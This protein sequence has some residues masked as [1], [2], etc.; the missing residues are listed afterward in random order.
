LMK[1]L[2][3]FSK[4][5]Y[6]T[7]KTNLTPEEKSVTNL[8]Y[9]IPTKTGDGPTLHTITALLSNEAGVLSRVSGT[10]AARGYNIAS[11][12]VAQTEVPQISRATLVIK[13]S[14]ARSI[15]QARRDLED[16]VQVWA[17]VEYLPTDS[18]LEREMLLIK[19]QLNPGSTASPVHGGSGSTSMS[20]SNVRQSI[21][22]LTSMFGGKVLDIT[23]ETMT[24][25]LCAKVSRVDSFI[26]LVAPFGISESV[27]SGPMAMKRGVFSG[28]EEEELEVSK[29]DVSVEDL[30]PG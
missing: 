26:K 19:L 5:R 30:P 29:V 16:L 1:Q 28:F 23:N 20:T 27:R 13:A 6:E 18:V 17:V 3:P 11:L 14:F 10:L 15:L 9:D 24:I 22:E 2:R 7:I 8:L 21:A 4:A 25:E 12:V